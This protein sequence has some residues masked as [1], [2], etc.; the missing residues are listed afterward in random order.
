VGVIWSNLLVQRFRSHPF[1][2]GRCRISNAF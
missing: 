2:D 1:T